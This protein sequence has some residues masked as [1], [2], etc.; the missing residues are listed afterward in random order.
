[1]D[2]Q[3]PSP[4]V[5]N[6]IPPVIT[7]VQV[8]PPEQQIPSSGSFF[9]NWLFWIFIVFVLLLSF[10]V[11]DF[12]LP[13]FNNSFQADIQRG[14]KFSVHVKKLTVGSPSFVIVQREELGLPGDWLA[15]SPYLVPDSYKDF[16][17]PIEANEMYTQEF[18]TNQMSN[19][20]F[21]ITVYKD[22]GDGEF[23]KNMDT[24]ILKDFYGRKLQLVV[25]NGIVQ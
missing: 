10:L 1:M 4:Q 24:E 21:Y 19:G 13:Y 18:L 8:L 6:Q 22:N 3:A 17:L 25:V 5:T 7:A 2:A 12:V 20:I 23:N 15:F 11:Y 14:A 9:K 16:Y